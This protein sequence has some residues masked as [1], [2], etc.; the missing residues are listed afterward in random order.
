MTFSLEF[1]GAAGG[2]TGSRTL[3]K[4]DGYQALVDCGLFQG[5]KDIRQKNR[6]VL[7]APDKR[8]DAIVLTHAHLDHSGYLPRFFNQGWRGPIFCSEGTADLLRPGCRGSIYQRRSHHW[9]EYGS[10]L[11]SAPQWNKN[12]DL[13]R[14]PR[15]QSKPHHKT[16]G[17]YQ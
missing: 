1:F 17:P 14:G 9:R 6:D 13:Q 8:V 15:A 7:L 2:V 10:I 11:F 5:P 16:A 12:S 4:F 3:V